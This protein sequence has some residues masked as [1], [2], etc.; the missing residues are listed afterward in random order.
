MHQLILAVAAASVATFACAQGAPDDSRW[1]DGHAAGPPRHGHHEGEWR[2]GRDGAED[3]H[4]G[5]DRMGGPGLA[6]LFHGLNL[7]PDQRLKIHTLILSPRLQHLQQLAAHKPGESFD[8]SVLLNPGDPNYNA[9]V[10][11][12]KKDAADRVQRMSDL[13]VQLYNVLTPEQKAELTKHI[14]EWKA[15]MAQREGGARDLPG[16]AAR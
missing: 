11:A 2:G 12:A 8:R 4:Q 13:K 16:P 14:G 1:D 6:H 7:T 10:Q 9:A 15:R 5:G 3:W